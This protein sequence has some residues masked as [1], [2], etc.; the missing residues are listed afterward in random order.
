MASY[1]RN[2]NQMQEEALARLREM[3]SRSRTAVNRPGQQQHPQ[4]HDPLPHNHHSH[5]PHHETNRPPQSASTQDIIKSLLGD[6]KIDS[7]KALI[8]L[9]LFVLYKNKADAKLLLALGYLL[10]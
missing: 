9:M 6:V 10:I 1:E 2:F 4:H 7:E 3:Q 8:L 5:E